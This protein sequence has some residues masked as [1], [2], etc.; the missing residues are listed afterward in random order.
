MNITINIE[1]PALVK[2][3]ESLAASLGESSQPSMDVNQQNESVQ[4]QSP[5]PVEVRQPVQQH[6]P[7]Q[8]HHPVQQVP[9]QQ[10]PTQ[11]A[12]VQQPEQQAPQQQQPVP[13]SA[14]TYSFDQLALAA[15]QLMDAGKQQD[16]LQLMASFNVNALTALPKDHYGAFATKLR[17][18]GAKI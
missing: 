13:T 12:P 1:A 5:A 2:A 15:T 9:V 8:Q 6:L 3:I 11:Q 7:N 4:Q 17:E 14:P 16:L 10:V 18:L